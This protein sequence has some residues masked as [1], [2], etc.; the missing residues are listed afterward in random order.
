MYYFCYC[1][2][3]LYYLLVA[4]NGLSGSRLHRMYFP[5]Y[6]VYRACSNSIALYSMCHICALQ[7]RRAVDEYVKVQLKEPY[8][9]GQIS[10]VDHKW[11]REKAVSKV[12]LCDNTPPHLGL[13][14]V[15]CLSYV[16]RLCFQ[17]S[18]SSACV[19]ALVQRC[20]PLY[21]VGITL[22]GD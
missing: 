4:V 8:S 5:D 13:C 3:W 9:L 12:R 14:D 16:Y 15:A 7:V 19:R 2:Y 22:S 10:K 17:C 6:T 18:S 20:D 11:V 1:Y 21:R